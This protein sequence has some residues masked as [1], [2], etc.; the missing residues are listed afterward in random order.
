MNRINDVELP[1]KQDFLQAQLS[2]G[3]PM[4]LILNAD[5]IDYQ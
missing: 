1:G 5:D 3:L 2:S 4:M